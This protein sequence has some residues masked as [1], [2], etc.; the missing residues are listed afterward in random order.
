MDGL[1]EKINEI[2]ADHADN[3]RRYKEEEESLTRAGH[4]LLV[5]IKTEE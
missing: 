2:L 5:I 1:S 3:I 4:T